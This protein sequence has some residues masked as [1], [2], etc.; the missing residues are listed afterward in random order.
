MTFVSTWPATTKYREGYHRRIDR[1]NLTRLGTC[2]FCAQLWRRAAERTLAYLL[3]THLF[4]ET[5]R[6]G[7]MQQRSTER[8]RATELAEYWSIRQGCIA[9]KMHC[10]TLYQASKIPLEHSG[11]KSKRYSSILHCPRGDHPFLEVKNNT[12]KKWEKVSPRRDFKFSNVGRMAKEDGGFAVLGKIY[13]SA[14]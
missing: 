14:D 5:Y 11:C 1:C 12:T 3:G 10:W 7:H 4:F 13:E 8:A 6:S 2:I 9:C